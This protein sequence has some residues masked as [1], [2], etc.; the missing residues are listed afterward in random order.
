MPVGARQVRSSEEWR[1][2]GAAAEVSQRE[3]GE[4]REEESVAE[5]GEKEMRREGTNE[6]K[7]RRVKGRVGTP[8]PTHL[9][10]TTEGKTTT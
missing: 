6:E 9:Q 1:V 5:G 2:T 8:G 4:G 7:L 3:K 10:G